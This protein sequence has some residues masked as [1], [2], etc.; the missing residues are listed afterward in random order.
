M[1]GSVLS[2][3]ALVALVGLGSACGTSPTPSQQAGTEKGPSRADDSTYLPVAGARS[4]RPADFVGEWGYSTRC[5]MGHYVVLSIS[6]AGDG[7][8]GSWS[9]G[10]NSRGSDGALRGSVEGDRALIQLCGSDAK[11][12]GITQCPHYED[13]E[14]FLKRR[15]RSLVWYRRSGTHD[16]E[17]VELSRGSAGHPSEEQCDD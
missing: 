14:G 10:T 5:N 16:E 11:Q 8:V 1:L 17:Y 12:S 4:S 9:D 7:L 13:A 2:R 3:G 15:G 6:E